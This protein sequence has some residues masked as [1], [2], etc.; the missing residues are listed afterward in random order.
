MVDD[1]RARDGTWVER[2]E[3][4]FHGTN[5]GYVERQLQEHNGIYHTDHLD[6]Y[7]ARNCAGFAAATAVKRAVQYDSE[8][9]LLITSSK[10]IGSH[11][12][13]GAHC[14]VIRWGWPQDQFVTLDVPVADP[15]VFPYFDEG[16]LRESLTDRLKTQTLFTLPRDFSFEYLLEHGYH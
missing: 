5:K 12:V 2:E 16:K 7:V 3:V 8:P 6:I 11:L 1:M 14:M 10:T 13:L 15:A 4:W 9:V